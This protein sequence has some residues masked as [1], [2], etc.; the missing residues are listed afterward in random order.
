MADPLSIA[1]SALA[2]IT[3]AI[4]STKS[5]V[6]TVKRFKDR[7]KTLRRLQAELEDL[8]NI[9][10]ALA[11]VTATEKSML[12]LLGDPIK[13]CSQICCEFEQSMNVFSEKSKMG[14]R[15]WAKMEFKRGDINDFIDTIAGQTT[16]V[17]QHVL[18]EYNELVQDTV[19]NLEVYLRRIDE[20]LARIPFDTTDNTPGINLDLKDERAVTKQCLRIC[21]DAKSYIESLANR[22]S[23]LL[24]EAPPDTANDDTERLFDAQLLTR[25]ALEANRD[26]FAEV[27]GHL[28]RRLQTLVL[29]RNPE[30]DNDRQRLQEDINISMKCLEVCKVASEVSR[31]KIYR[32]GEAVADGDSD[33]VVV[34]TLADLFDVKK[35]LSTGNSAQLV[36]SMTD[37]ALCHLADKRYGSRFGVSAHPTGATTTKSPP[38]FETR[39]SKHSFP[40]QSGNDERFSKL[41]TRRNEP[42]P[43]E[44]R[45]R[46]TSDKK[47]Q[48]YNKREAGI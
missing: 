21:Q 11:H 19:Y 25:Q 4:Q 23:D 31:Q 1:A 24:Q 26:S 9:L 33:Q 32:V 14:F 48:D 41:E 7:D 29:D 18:E 2:V 22:E 20:K 15:D 10:D 40:P 38:A 46:A 35:A 8:A 43:N 27:I 16:K 34:T 6:D 45:K 12:A 30:N 44:M 3:A 42:S 47:D 37:D 17:S 36:G 13:R 28:G 39:R 5:L